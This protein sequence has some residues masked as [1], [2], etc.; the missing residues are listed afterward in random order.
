[1]FRTR[2]FSQI[3]LPA[4]L[5]LAGCSSPRPGAD[6]DAPMFGRNRTS[7]TFLVSAEG[8]VDVD[9]IATVA[10]IIGP[11]RQ[12]TPAEMMDVE[13]RL[14]RALDRLVDLEMQEMEKERKRAPLSSPLRKRVVTREAARQRVIDRLGKD[15]ALPLITSDNRSAVVFGRV[16]NDKVKLS[17]TAYEIDQKPVKDTFQKVTTPSGGSAV[18]VDPIP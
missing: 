9:E 14:E 3:H 1:M 16:S 11:Y 18:V 10:R 4:F 12:L 17:S 5:L 2:L 7:S 15:L 8:A 6:P 13:R